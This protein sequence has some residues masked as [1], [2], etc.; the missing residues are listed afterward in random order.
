MKRSILIDTA[1]LVLRL[2]V[3]V[4]FVAHGAQ[5]L[6]GAFGGG[7]IE[8]LTQMLSGLGFGMPLFW[9][10]ALAISEFLAGIFLIV[11]VLPRLSASLIAIIMVV[12]I[13]TV[14]GPEGFFAM[15]GGFEYQLLTIAACVSLILT[16]AGKFSLFDKL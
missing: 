14:H 2:A 3:G 1:I 5:K 6:F 13:T 16:G 11:G 10:W 12:A 7:G 15:Q 4:I 8:G 9:A